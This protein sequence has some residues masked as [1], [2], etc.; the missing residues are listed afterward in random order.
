MVFHHFVTYCINIL[1]VP[2]PVRWVY[3]DGPHE[4]WG[5]V[6]T[7]SGPA[8]VLYAVESR[9]NIRNIY[10]CLLIFWSFAFWWTYATTH[11]QGEVIIECCCCLPCNHC[12]IWTWVV[13]EIL[14]YGIDCVLWTAGSY[15]IYNY[16]FPLASLELFNYYLTLAM[17]SDR[18]A[19]YIIQRNDTT[20]ES[21]PNMSGGM[22][23]VHSK[24]LRDVRILVLVSWVTEWCLL[25]P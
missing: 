25:D 19:Y 15:L 21:I 20:I 18:F 14:A 23:G 5:G 12:S 4:L 10:I 9:L 24:M 6:R 16:A 2:V 8:A 1:L 17:S 13:E 22:Q 7:H 3:R 11:G